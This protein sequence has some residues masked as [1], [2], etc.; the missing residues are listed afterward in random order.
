MENVKVE[1]KVL[2]SGLET[3]LV[4]LN[5]QE[6]MMLPELA[7]VLGI[8]RDTLSYHCR[9][10]N[11]SMTSV[12]RQTQQHFRKIGI[13]PMEGRSPSFLPR[14]TVEALVKLVGTPEAWS[15]YNDLWQVVKNVQSGNLIEAQQKVG[16]S[17]DEVLESLE[18]ALLLAKNYK[19]QKEEAETKVSHLTVVVDNSKI[20]PED[21]ERLRIAIV[22]KAKE[23]FPLFEEGTKFY[24]L[25]GTIRKI[26]KAMFN[27]H[28]NNTHKEI[29]VKE[30]DD[31]LNFIE[32]INVDIIKASRLYG[33]SNNSL[34]ALRNYLQLAIKKEGK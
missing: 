15:I 2:K 23:L 24:S 5:G 18:K 14:E 19:K 17:D 12:A 30:L 34:Q 32:K 16:L 29:S 6:G 22:N 11:L 4:S 26:I 8:G 9:R 1:K 33:K 7:K 21:M 20:G 27:A 10:N 3:V 28:A 13:I 31:C 25:T